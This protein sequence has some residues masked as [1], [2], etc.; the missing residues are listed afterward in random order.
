MAGK[1][2]YEE[3]ERRVKEFEQAEFERKQGEEDLREHR[4]ILESIINGVSML[5][6]YVDREERYVFINRAYADWHGVSR[7]ELIGK[8]VS[9]ILSPD[10][11]EKAAGNIKKAL[12]GQRVSYTN[13][14]IAKD[15]SERYVSAV[16]DPHCIKNEVNGFFAT[17][18]DITDRKKAKESL[19]LK[20]SIIRSSSSAI[21]TCSLEGI[22]T[23]GNPFFQK[24]WGFVN[25]GEFLGKS[26]LDFW[27]L[28]D[29]YE[30]VMKALRTEGIWTGEL[31]A[32]RK[33]GT[34]FDVQV[35]AA[36][37][38]D[39]NG[40]PIALTSTTID[41]TEKKR[42]EKALRESDEQR[43][44]FLDNVPG[45]A[46]QGYESDG[47]TIYWNRASEK[48]YGYTAGEAIG[49]NLLD[50]IIP[51]NMR[52]EVQMA[53]RQMVSTGEPIPAGELSLQRKDGSY[54]SVHSGHAIV[55]IPGK[56][57]VL[58]CM[59][60]DLTER[61]DA[62][63]K[64]IQLQ[65][66]ESLHRMAGAIAHHFNNQLSVVVGN[67]ELAL[68]DLPA[69]AR[70]RENLINAMQAARRSSEV[71]GLML[72]CLGQGTGKH[73]LLDLSKVCLNNLP[74]LHD[75]IPKGIAFEADFKN[76]G[77]IVRAAENRILQVLIHLITNG[78]ESIGEG[79]GKVTLA[80][81]TI[82]ASD[83][84]KSDIVPNDWKST[85]EILACIEVKDTGCGIAEEDKDKI[86]DP[87]F[88]TKFTGRGLGLPVVLG[89]V[90]ACDGAIGVESKSGQ[91][92][93]FRVFLPLV[94]DEVPRWSKKETNAHNIGEGGTVLLVDD[95][96]MV[97]NMITSMLKR[98]GFTVLAAADGTEALEL[99]RQHQNAIHCVIT[100][101]TM[102][103]MD[104]WQ[105]L[106][107]LR[108]IQ[109]D[110]PVILASGY[111]EAQAMG[112]D[113]LEQ[114]PNAFLHKPYSMDELKGT[115]RQALGG[116][117]Q[118]VD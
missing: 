85:A 21:A 95:Q 56:Q 104:G 72:T 40:N 55:Q 35:S 36:T 116:K 117:T 16:Y 18:V 12:K 1:P 32:K 48:L 11:Y 106:A 91:G 15:G 52:A 10:A 74:M 4:E 67:L 46:I 86:F 76:S 13:K 96:D 9:D 45:L 8:K 80:T 115:L 23:Y 103:G 110:L 17:I 82:S 71:S 98:L 70:P 90:K 77:L 49:K 93:I 43:R 61:K 75:A 50:L 65:K 26:F 73:E 118:K 87:F 39:S 14:V 5:I 7:K 54:I 114:R 97:R 101:L 62:E 31:K 30:E 38:F 44:L 19:L 2:T 59:D 53:I 69:D 88:T 78:L 84:S 108:E 81:R 58:F 57:P 6:T 47:T 99:F 105:I 34:L 102:P 111:D 29:K 63:T 109:P 51:L 68:D 83:I 100:D 25:P 20:D 112:R 37:V 33:D 89:I 22:M 107:A 42:A 94:T 28:G 113:D 66:V 41:L 60:F 79:T 92:S 64:A 3:L 24:L 27:L